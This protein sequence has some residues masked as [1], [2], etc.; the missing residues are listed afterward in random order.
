MTGN[1]EPT[2]LRVVGHCVDLRVQFIMATPGLCRGQNRVASA[3]IG[4]GGPRER[5]ERRPGVDQA[6]QDRRREA[7]V[8]VRHQIGAQTEGPRPVVDLEDEERQDNETDGV[9]TTV[10]RQ[11]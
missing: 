6:P 5:Q 11:P 10:E 8:R 4:A 9:T 3:S 1:F 7:P 2:N